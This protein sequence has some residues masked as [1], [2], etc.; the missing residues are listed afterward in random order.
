MSE[1]ATPQRFDH[2][3]VY[4]RS[5]QY[6]NFYRLV[7]ACILLGNYFV[8][9]NQ[10]FQLNYN[11]SFY[12]TVASNYVGF[13]IITAA[14]GAATAVAVPIDWPRFNRRL[15][16][17]VIGDITFIVLLMHASGGVRSGVGL[18]LVV[19]IATTSLVTQGRLALFYAALAAGAVL[20]EQSYRVS[21]MSGRYEDYSYAVLLGACFFATAGLAHYFARRTRQS[22]ELASQRGV[23]LKNL[24]AVN[25]LVIRDMQDGV[26][27]VDQDFKLR[28]FNSQAERLLEAPAQ[29]WKELPLD[30]YSRHVA[31]RLRAWMDGSYSRSGSTANLS[32]GGRE[33]RL[34]FLPVGADRKQGAVIFVED[35]SRVQNQAQQLKLAALG[36]LTANIAHEIRNPLSAIGHASQLLLEDEHADPTTHRLLQIIQSNVQRLDS[37]VQDVL[38]LNRRDRAQTMALPASTFLREFVEQFRQVEGIAE[39]GLTLEM[40]SSEATPES[41]GAAVQIAFDRHHLHQILWNLCRNGWRHS[42]QQAGSLRLRVEESPEN[43]AIILDVID[44][45]PG[46]EAEVAQRLF[47]P[48][49]TT[50]TSGTG[51]G[52]YIAREL[53]EANSASLEYIESPQ[54]GWFR[55][56]AKKHDS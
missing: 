18:L 37:I 34:R 15:T 16:L 47:E 20:L 13:S 9:R 10:H 48:F 24:A 46:I 32:L 22:E 42:K 55:I 28:H 14:I 26:L 38:Q 43:G 44:D 52:L 1:T 54:G 2:Q 53:C 30:N 45:G 6:F 39:G 7:S 11:D 51:L 19:V 31:K 3:N 4:W 12:L 23:D 5:L 27:V 36:R 29:P 21:I 8:M 41:S 17:L 25:Q 50:E 33:L 40:A 49:F 35:W 56:Y